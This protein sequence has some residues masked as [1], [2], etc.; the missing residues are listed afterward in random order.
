MKFQY[1]SGERTKLI[2][3]DIVY[4]KNYVERGYNAIDGVAPVDIT[5]WG[6]MKQA[7]RQ[8]KD[9]EV[10]S[11]FKSVAVDTVDIAA[12]LCEKYVCAQNGVSKLGE[13]PYGQGWTLVKKEFE[14]TFRSI[15]QLGYAVAFISHAKDKTFKRKDG[16]E[17]N[18]TVPS[19]PNSY[20][21]IAKNMAD[22]YAFAEK[23]EEEGKA[24]VRLVLRS[25]DN[26]ADTGSRFK[27]IQPILPDF[28]YDAVVKA[29]NDAID[30]QAEISKNPE[31][32]TDERDTYAVAPT[33]NYEELIEEFSGLAS[34]LMSN[35]PA[36]FEPRIVSIVDKYLGRGKKVSEATID[37]A[38]LIS[39]I[40]G[41]ITDELLPLMEGNQ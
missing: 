35:N 7:L 17:Y 5:T 37:Q 8:L 31:L 2:V 11:E 30:K 38:E 9:P 24:K 34:T 19:C 1:R 13:I 41:E 25:P 26:S 14:E 12:A 40:N 4:N 10:Q 29:L 28:S 32:F 22:I 33:F 20:N 23:Y 18:Q 21:E 39:L 6:E 15:T 36:F 27:Y 3:R 16:T